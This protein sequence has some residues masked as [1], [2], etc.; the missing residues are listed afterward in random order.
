MNIW[1]LYRKDSVIKK[2][3]LTNSFTV[4]LVFGS[5]LFVFFILDL[6][7]RIRIPIV[8]V[9]SLCYFR[10]TMLS[11]NFADMKKWSFLKLRYVPLI[12][13]ILYWTQDHCRGKW[14]PNSN[15]ISFPVLIF[16]ACTFCASLYFVLIF[17]FILHPFLHSLYDLIGN[18]FSV[19]P[20]FNFFPEIVLNAY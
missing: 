16:V 20:V 9:I 17:L 5:F 11:I 1:I 15:N 19:G 6:S 4:F 14:F 2:F 7:C 18:Q 13:V 10:C 12:S 3:S 8:R